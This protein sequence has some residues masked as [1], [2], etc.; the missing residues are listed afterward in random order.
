M[1]N[2]F[3]IIET[4]NYQKPKMPEKKKKQLRILILTLVIAAVLTSLAAFFVLP[5]INTPFEYDISSLDCTIT[6]L[7]SGTDGEIVVPERI[8]VFKVKTIYSK[9]FYDCRVTD[10]TVCEGVTTIMNNAFYYCNDLTSITLPDTITFI[11]ENAFAHCDRLETIKCSEFTIYEWN[12]VTKVKGWNYA[13]KATIVCTD[14][15]ILPDGTEIYNRW[16]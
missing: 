14:G 9:A 13:S 5:L 1:D 10:I 16:E 2:N 7:K 12:A 15:I 11:G 6:G 8:S 4:K 3:P